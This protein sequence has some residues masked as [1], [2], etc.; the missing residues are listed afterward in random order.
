VAGDAGFSGVSNR[1]VLE[2][3]IMTKAKKPGIS[4]RIGKRKD[5]EAALQQRNIEAAH[6]E[7]ERLK[8]ENEELKKRDFIISSNRNSF[9]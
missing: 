1:L 6:Q 9:M 2:V 5:D 3:F 4:Q 7:V 8:A